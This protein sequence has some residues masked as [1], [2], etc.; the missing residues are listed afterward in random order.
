[1]KKYFGGNCS[2]NEGLICAPCPSS[3]LWHCLLSMSDKVVITHNPKNL[4][5]T[6]KLRWH[7]IWWTMKIWPLCDTTKLIN[8]WMEE[9][10][11]LS[12]WYGIGFILLHMVVIE[13]LLINRQLWEQLSLQGNLHLDRKR[14]YAHQYQHPRDSLISAMPSTHLWILP[15]LRRLLCKFGSLVEICHNLITP[16]KPHFHSLY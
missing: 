14:R 16:L 5:F 9:V 4:L 8:K 1:M 3:V 13:Y 6:E 10:Y 11:M 15:L 2:K 12:Q 7:R